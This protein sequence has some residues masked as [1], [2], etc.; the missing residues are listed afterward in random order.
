MAFALVN[1][2]SAALGS[3][4]GTTGTIDTTGADLLVVH[5][6]K[7]DGST[8]GASGGTLSDSKS[9]TWTALTP[10]DGTDAVSRIFYCENPTVGTGHDFTFGNTSSFSSIEVLAFSGAKVAGSYEAENGATGSGTSL[11]PGS[12]TPT[13]NG[14]LIFTGKCWNASITG[15][16]INSS[17]TLQEE[18]P[19][20]GGTNMGSAAA[21]L[22]QGTAGAI[23][24]TWSWTTSVSAAATI[25]VFLA[26]DGGGGGVSADAPIG[27]IAVSALSPSST[28]QASLAAAVAEVFGNSPTG[29]KSAALSPAVV[30]IAANVPTSTKLASL[31]AA[32]VDVFG[33]VP[34][35]EVAIDADAPIGLV[36]VSGLV[37]ASTKAATLTPGLAEV[38]GLVPTGESAGVINA[39]IGPVAVLGLAPGSAKLASLAAAAVE[40]TAIVP[41]GYKLAS[42]SPGV[43][44]VVGNVPTSTKSATLIVGVIEVSG[45]VPI[46]GDP[47]AVDAVFEFVVMAAIVPQMGTAQAIVPQMATGQK[48]NL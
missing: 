47:D 29:R 20:G 38:I 30:D 26:E 8:G 37:P 42:V 43:L 17:F 11:Q 16:S 15:L 24:P 35:T 23:N 25:A 3:N 10:Q 33:V 4:G 19:Y 34:D 46:G 36:D 44:E 40:V 21:Y 39:P 6:G 31:V 1:S 9:N 45:V 13:E 18:E 28:K 2:I 14:A 48:L 22:I 7:F 27:L 32:G 12:V 41:T 5:V